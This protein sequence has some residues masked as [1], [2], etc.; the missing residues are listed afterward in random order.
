MD[1][2]ITHAIEST[3]FGAQLIDLVGTETQK[4][5]YLPALCTGQMRM[6]VAITEPDAGSDVLNVSTKAVKQDGGY[7]ING[8]KMFISNGDYADF[9]VTLCL[10][11]PDAPTKTGR[12]SVI[13]IDGNRP[14][15]ERNKIHGKLGI[16][17]HDT[18]EITF[19]TRM[20]A[21]SKIAIVCD[22]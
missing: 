17:A 20:Q 12:H 8:N 19:S 16:R 14:G 6:G 13:V 2:G 5:K 3:F 18:A 7:L 4:K 9:F 1:L 10:T 21:I 11:N 15:I 22:G